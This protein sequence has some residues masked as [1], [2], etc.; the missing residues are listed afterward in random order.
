MKN[1]VSGLVPDTPFFFVKTLLFKVFARIN[2]QNVT[3][4]FETY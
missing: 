1:G 2:F 4:N 3:I